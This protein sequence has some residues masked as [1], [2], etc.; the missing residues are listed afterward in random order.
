MLQVPVGDLVAV[1]LDRGAPAALGRVT[2]LVATP[3]RGVEDLG[4]LGELPQLEA[5]QPGPLA[6][7]QHHR[8]PLVGLEDRLQG[9]DVGRVAHHHPVADG[10]G[11]LDDLE[12]A[13]GR[14]GE[15]GHP[16]CWRK[17][18]GSSRRVNQN[19]S[20]LRHGTRTPGPDDPPGCDGY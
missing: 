20:G 19:P 7:D 15:E 4:V 18:A 8:E 16:A 14:A 2:G 17:K 12:E 10:Q 5:E 11:R 13:V 3:G 9:P 6:V 1:A